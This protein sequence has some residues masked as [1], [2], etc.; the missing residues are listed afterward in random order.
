M[1]SYLIN[2]GTNSGY[3]L[4][5]T[6]GSPISRFY[7]TKRL[8]ECLKFCRVDTQNITPHSFRIGDA[9]HAARCGHSDNDVKKMGRWKSNA[10]SRYICLPSLQVRPSPHDI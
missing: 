9:T 10:L 5:R 7:F 6:D 1:R 2:R 8:N 4:V 3:L